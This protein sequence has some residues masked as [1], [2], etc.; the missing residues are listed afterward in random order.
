MKIRTA[1]WSELEDHQVAKFESGLVNLLREQFQ[2]CTAEGTPLSVAMMDVD[3][4][5]RINDSFSHAVGDEVLRQLSRLFLD[6]KRSTDAVGRY[7]GEEFLLIMPNTTAEMAA[8]LVERLRKAIQNAPWHSVA[9]T[10]QVTLSI[11]VADNVGQINY[12][13]MVAAA[14][15]KLYEAKRSRNAVEF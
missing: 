13:K 1:Q 5:K 3:H 14:D 15:G 7:G 6:N 10:L 8:V 12:E 11:G 9:P 2:Q 4:F